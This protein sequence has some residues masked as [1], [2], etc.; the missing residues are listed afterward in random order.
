MV[1]FRN[2]GTTVSHCDNILTTYGTARRLKRSSVPLLRPYLT[3]LWKPRARFTLHPR[4][5]ASKHSLQE[6]RVHVCRMCI[7]LQE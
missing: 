1:S 6:M 5:A 3:E 2:V 4:G 7:G